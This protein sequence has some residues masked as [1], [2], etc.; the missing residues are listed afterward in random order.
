MTDQAA[1]SPYHQ[2]QHGYAEF[3][4]RIAARARKQMYRSLVDVIGEREPALVLDVGVTSD[5]EPGANFFE[6]LYPHPHRITAVGLEDA[7]FLEDDFP[8]LRYVR[9]DALALPF[10]DRE[11]DVAVSFAVIEHV[12]S[13]DRQRAFVRELCRVSKH[14]CI[15]TPNRW[16]PVEFHTVLPFA[17]WLPPSTFHRVCRALGKDFYA[18][19]DNLNLLDDKSFR[20]LIPAD[21]RIETR[22]HRLL[23]MVSNLVFHI[24]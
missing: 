11:F 16:F 18:S 13:R 10:G 7:S 5:R 23:G 2:Y 4:R 8:G 20:Q 17:H 24:S 22:H 14:V 19:E 12:G 1:D 3:T 6:K 21:M 9:A 15:T